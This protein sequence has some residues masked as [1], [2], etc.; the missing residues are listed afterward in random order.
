MM[1][2]WAVPVAAISLQDSAGALNLVAVLDEVA[3]L[4]R[5]VASSRAAAAR[6]VSTADV[7]GLVG[8]ELERQA[9]VLRTLE[10]YLGELV[11]DFGRSVESGGAEEWLRSLPQ[12][13]R[14]GDGWVA[15]CPK[16]VPIRPLVA[17][18][19]PLQQAADLAAYRARAALP[20]LFEQRAARAQSGAAA[21]GV[22]LETVSGLADA[23][24]MLDNFAFATP[25]LRRFAGLLLAGGPAVAEGAS[26]DERAAV[27]GVNGGSARAA[28]LEWVASAE[29]RPE[30]GFG[31]DPLGSQAASASDR[32]DPPRSGSSE[33][34]ATAASDDEAASEPTQASSPGDQLRRRDRELLATTRELLKMMEERDQARELVRQQLKTVLAQCIPP[35]GGQSRYARFALSSPTAN[36]VTLAKEAQVLVNRTLQ[37]VPAAVAALR[38]LP[39]SS[40]AL[41]EEPTV[42]SWAAQAGPGVAGPEALIRGFRTAHRRY[43]EELRAAGVWGAVHLAQRNVQQ[44]RGGGQPLARAEL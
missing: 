1:R 12:D 23:S 17:T 14:S 42:T 24:R 43:L 9:E 13:S 39:G 36:A 8:G 34:G 5:D 4:F 25:E 22:R 30:E 37:V 10:Q 2:V 26:A 19:E 3:T 7:P 28:A 32:K 11:G 38:D 20:R 41:G 21:G 16:E 6:L 33:Q 18:L 15:L 44:H 31:A 29:A 27:S 40:V 35:T